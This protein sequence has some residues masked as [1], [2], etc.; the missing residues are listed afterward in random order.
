MVIPGL[1][2]RPYMLLSIQKQSGVYFNVTMPPE[3]VH[4]PNTYHVGKHDIKKRF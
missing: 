1:L 2:E 3:N 4:Y